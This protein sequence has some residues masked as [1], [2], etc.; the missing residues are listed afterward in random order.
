MAQ[1]AQQPPVSAVAGRSWFWPVVSFV[2]LVAIAVALFIVARQNYIGTAPYTFKSVFASNL[3]EGAVIVIGGAGIAAVLSVIQEMRA[4]RERDMAKRLEFFRRMR[5]AHVRIVRARG[6]LRAD[7]SPETYGKQMRALMAVTRDLEELRMEVK[8]S[9]RLYR[10]DRNSI[11]EGIS[12]IIIF[13]E[14]ISIEY[15]D[16]CK[17]PNGLKGKPRGSKWVAD[18]IKPRKSPCPAR[19]PSNEDWELTDVMPDD[20]DKALSKSKGMMRAYAYGTRVR[21]T[22]GCVDRTE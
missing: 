22:N 5:A 14:R 13:L 11:M 3:P 17:S 1:D 12:K 18:L 9:G 7:D 21:P 20:Y 10:H 8:V 4:K 16:W 19:D 6:L 2:V 15:I